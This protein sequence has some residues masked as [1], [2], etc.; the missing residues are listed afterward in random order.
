MMGDSSI[1]VEMSDWVIVCTARACRAVT[2]NPLTFDKN[3]AV[4][5]T[6]RSLTAENCTR[7]NLT[8]TVS[9]SGPYAKFLMGWGQPGALSKATD[10]IS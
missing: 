5:T 2:T 4:A 6:N 8:Q 1:K 7:G 10:S 3:S 9:N